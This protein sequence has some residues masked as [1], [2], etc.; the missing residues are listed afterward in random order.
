M[1]EAK[2]RIPFMVGS[3]IQIPIMVWAMIWIP[4]M[5]WAKILI[6]T[7]VGA[8]IRIPI[9]V[10]AKVLIPIM[11]WAKIQNQISLRSVSG[12]EVINKSCV[13][14]YTYLSLKHASSAIWKW[15]RLSYGFAF[16]FQRKL[17]TFWSPFEAFGFLSISK[18]DPGQESNPY[19]NSGWSCFLKW[20]R[21]SATL[22]LLNWT[23]RFLYSLIHQFF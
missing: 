19:E 13:I 7:M 17:N 8:K 6:T 11:V 4:V 22:V 20:G 16:D 2:I 9:I 15:M 21:G 18:L 23:F 5:G 14:I 12:I 3:K 10:G 1:I